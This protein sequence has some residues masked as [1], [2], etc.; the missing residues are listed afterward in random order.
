MPQLAKRQ[1]KESFHNL[2]FPRIFALMNTIFYCF[3]IRYKHKSNNIVEYFKE[4]PA[5]VCSVVASVLAVVILDPEVVAAVVVVV[6]FTVVLLVAVM[7]AV[8]VVVTVVVVVEL[9][10]ASK[11]SEILSILLEYQTRFDSILLIAVVNALA[12]VVWT[13]SVNEFMKACS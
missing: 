5:P 9:S 8:V 2:T 12:C 4:C 1:S 7:G 13:S 6:V 10:V 11:Y 3:I